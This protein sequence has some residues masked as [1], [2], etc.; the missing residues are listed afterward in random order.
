MAGET[1]TLTNKNGKKLHEIEY[2]AEQLLAV[3]HLI[4]F[5]YSLSRP[6]ESLQRRYITEAS[7]LAGLNVLG[8]FSREMTDNRIVRTFCVGFQRSHGSSPDCGSSTGGCRILMHKSPFWN[9]DVIIDHVLNLSCT[10]SWSVNQD[11]DSS[12]HNIR[13]KVFYIKVL[14]LVSFFLSLFEE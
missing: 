13:K 10:P 7:T 12:R 8:S 1:I 11:I 5:S 9:K 3:T 4:I 2:E 6:F 14:E